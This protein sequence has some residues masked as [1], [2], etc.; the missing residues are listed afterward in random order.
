MCAHQIFAIEEYA[1]LICRKTFSDNSIA[2][3][4]VYTAAEGVLV[5]SISTPKI[6]GYTALPTDTVTVSLTGTGIRIAWQIGSLGILAETIEYRNNIGFR[7][8]IGAFN[9]CQT[10][11]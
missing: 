11:S 9:T 6:A 7:V 10:G 5:G 3:I 2:K 8:H 1:V 4:K